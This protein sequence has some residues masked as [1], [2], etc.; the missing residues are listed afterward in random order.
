MEQLGSVPQLR[1]LVRI[2]ATGCRA[3]ETS[4]RWTVSW[5]IDNL[6][7]RPLEILS[8]WLPHDKFYSQRSLF[9]PALQLPPGGT[10][11]LDLPVACQE[12]PGSRVEN[13]F[14]ILQLVLIGQTWRAFARHLITVDSAGVPQPHCQAIS[15][16]PVGVASN[17]GTSEE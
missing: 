11:D 13:A 9:N 8:A 17:G 10:V 2:L 6:G 14:V 1:P 15:V 7:D 12:P 3:I 5:R 4:G 16:H